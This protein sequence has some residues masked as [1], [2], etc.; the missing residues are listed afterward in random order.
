[1]TQNHN[2]GFKSRS[3]LE[4]V[5]QHA[6]EKQAIAII[7]RNYAVIRQPLPLRRMRFLEA[8]PLGRLH[9]PPCFSRH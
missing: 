4:A 5:A 2:F 6:D 8:T 7:N 3:R 1:M 9:P